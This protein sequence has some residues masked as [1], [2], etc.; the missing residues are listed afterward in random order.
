LKGTNLSLNSLLLDE[1]STLILDL[2]STITTN[3]NL[4]LAGKLV[5]NTLLN[6]PTS[7][8]G[9][10][11]QL[12]LFVALEGGFTGSFSDLSV[13]DS[14]VPC[15]ILGLSPIQQNET[16]VGEVFAASS[17]INCIPAEP[18]LVYL[19]TV[20]N[21]DLILNE[22]VL[23][24][25]A[26]GAN[27]TVVNGNVYIHN[28]AQLKIRSGNFTIHGSLYIIFGVVFVVRTESYLL[29]PKLQVEGDVQMGEESTDS[30]A[31]LDLSGPCSAEILGSVEM[32]QNSLLQATTE[33][34]VQIFGNLT[35]HSTAAIF[36]EFL[37]GP[38]PT[39]V[40]GGTVVPN[41]FLYIHGRYLT[42]LLSTTGFVMVH[43][44]RSVGQ[45]VDTTFAD[46][47]AEKAYPTSMP[48]CSKMMSQEL[49]PKNIRIRLLYDI[50]LCE[51]RPFCIW[52][53]DMPYLLLGLLL[54]NET[55]A[56]SRPGN[57][58]EGPFGLF[59]Y[60]KAPSPSSPTGASLIEKAQGFQA[61]I[62][63]VIIIA[64]LLLILI[65]FLVQV[66]LPSFPPPTPPVVAFDTKPVSPSLPHSI[67]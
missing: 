19:P 44:F 25:T 59:P 56:P 33:T 52:S 57:Y 14:K 27:S 53:V 49:V 16:L 64:A 45:L 54:Q 26:I 48:S 8:E 12:P 41:G 3:E 20:I 28:A 36:L 23:Y 42:Q 67:S 35:L 9:L 1:D 22:P 24:A 61:W 5:I 2:G 29:L 15:T 10:P 58:G 18:D 7:V 66:R 11:F 40:V 39:I 50:S 43:A 65:V 13:T 34:P 17:E 21:G 60:A 30:Q 47:K 51:V 32:W 31:A 63:A 6:P 46:L 37:S 38:T 4:T 55:P 62:I